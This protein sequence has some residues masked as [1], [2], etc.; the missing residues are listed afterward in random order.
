MSH[1]QIEV[2]LGIAMDGY[3]SRRSPAL[4]TRDPLEA[5]ALFVADEHRAAILVSLDLVAV[6]VRLVRQ[7]R[8]LIHKEVGV[9]CTL[10]AATHTH[11]GPTGVRTSTEGGSVTAAILD[12]VSSCVRRAAA[13]AAPVQVRVGTGQM[14]ATVATNRNDPAAP[15]DRR[16]TLIRLLGT[17]GTLVGLLW[18]TGVHP[19]VLGPDNLQYSADLPG[20]VRRRL[21]RRDEPVMFLNGPAGD[22]S[23]RFVR[24]SRDGAELERLGGLLYE[25]LP[26]TRRPIALAPVMGAERRLAVRAAHHDSKQTEQ[27]RKRTLRNLQ[28]Q[29]LT[30]G[31]RRR[32]ESVLEGLARLNR[33]QQDDVEAEV[34]VVRLGDLVVAAVP[35]EL[36]SALSRMRTKQPGVTL[37]LVGYANG[38]LGYL[39]EPRSDET[40]YET[41][42][43]RVDSG[44]G[45]RLI[46]AAADLQ[47]EIF[48]A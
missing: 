34:Q 42:V 32:L 16:L 31:E 37:L 39:T 35:G 21:R 8:R 6:D 40:T 17:D 29:G 18:H 2:P 26:P 41:L 12:A 46:T 24:R 5:T 33:H 38:Y 4:G 19:T 47:R 28:P 9:A 48:S 14:P 3:G 7:L 27:L 23:S 1:S 45:E 15:I 13:T 10:I 20:E 44:V 25:A 43:S 36:V 22:V 11:A 30:G